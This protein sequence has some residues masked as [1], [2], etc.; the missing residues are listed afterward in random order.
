MTPPLRHE[1]PSVERRLKKETVDYDFVVLG[2]GSA[3]YAGA[4]RAAQ[5]GMT[6]VLVEA[7]KLGG[8]CLHR[9]CIRT[10]ALLHS[11][12]TADAVRGA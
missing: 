8:T 6:V 2:G 9:G 5:L 3:G 4:L 11:P 12:E 1:A 7:D 10:K